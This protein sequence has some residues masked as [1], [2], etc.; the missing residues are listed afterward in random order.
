MSRASTPASTQ[1]RRRSTDN[2]YFVS[3]DYY[4]ENVAFELTHATATFGFPSGSGDT[5][6]VAAPECE[7]AMIYD[8][9]TSGERGGAT[10]WLGGSSH[11]LVDTGGEL[12]IFRRQQKRRTSAST[13]S[14]RM[15]PASS[16]AR[17]RS[18]SRPAS[19]GSS[20]PSPETRTT[21]PSTGCGL[22]PIL[23]DDL[24]NVTNAA[25]GQL[26]GGTG[27]RLARSAS[28]ELGRRL[29][30][31]HRR[32]PDRDPLP[33]RRRPPPD[34]RSTSILRVVQ[35]RPGDDAALARSTPG[36]SPD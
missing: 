17:T 19:A 29:R 14:R 33:A 11:F 26:I 6:K 30:D 1:P 2:N 7:D 25:V 34:G 5:P 36:A 15:A 13:P 18:R 16:A 23:E 10:I 32:Q 21:S 28:V 27:D 22:G 9:N 8:Q 3:G 35:F 31:R 12:E 20:R 4:F 24:G